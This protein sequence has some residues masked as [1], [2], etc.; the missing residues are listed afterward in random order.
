MVNALGRAIGIY[1]RNDRDV[2]PVGFF[3]SNVLF[4]DV[5]DEHHIGHS[6]HVL[7]A[8]EILHQA[9]V[10]AIEFE[11]FLF[12]QHLKTAVLTHRLDV[13]ELLDRFLDRLVVCQKATEPSVVDVK[14]SAAFRFFFDSL[15]CLTL[16]ADKENL[17]IGTLGKRFRD[18]IKS[19]AEKLLRFL[20]IYNINAVALSKDVLFHLRIP[21]AYLM[22]KMNSCLEEFFHRNCCQ[23]LFLLNYWFLYLPKTSL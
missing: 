3:D 18:V 4:T 15:L 20:Q 7:D 1:N 2:E 12:G 14:L 22:S 19:V 17:L 11:A 5:D 9:F 13:L 8:G 23:N 10:F 16:S 21:T 6:A